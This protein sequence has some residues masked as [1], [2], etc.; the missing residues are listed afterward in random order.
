ML[1]KKEVRGK[2]SMDRL[3]S[4]ALSY[5]PENVLLAAVSIWR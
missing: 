5:P 3:V 4:G 2:P 1:L